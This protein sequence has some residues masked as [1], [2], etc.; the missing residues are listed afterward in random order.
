MIIYIFIHQQAWLQLTQMCQLTC[1]KLVEGNM[2]DFDQFRLVNWHYINDG[3]P[4]EV[5]AAGGRIVLELRMLESG[6][7]TQSEQWRV[8]RLYTGG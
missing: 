8:D 3:H 2:K 5:S 6:A 4:G 7:G 1:Q